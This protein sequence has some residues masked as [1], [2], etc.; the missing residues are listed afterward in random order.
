[1]A[2]VDWCEVAYE[3]VSTNAVNTTACMI[4]S[5]T[6]ASLACVACRACHP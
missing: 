6:V 1:M 2:V 4:E 5:L 3:H